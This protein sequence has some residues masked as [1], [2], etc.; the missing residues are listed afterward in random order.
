MA[1]IAFSLIFLIELLL[2]V[3]AMGFVVHKYSYMRDWWNVL[4]F[5]IVVT[6]FLEFFSFN[7]DGF[8]LM[9]MLRLLKPL[10]SIKALKKLRFLI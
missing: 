7:Q 1:Y 6:S 10:R 5:I 3:I 2:K 9:R 4:D 8:T